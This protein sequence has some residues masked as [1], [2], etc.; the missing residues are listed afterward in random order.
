MF[1]YTG[2]LLDA[3]FFVFGWKKV[4]LKISEANPSLGQGFQAF[5]GFQVG[6]QPVYLGTQ[7]YLWKNKLIGSISTSTLKFLLLT[8]PET[9]HK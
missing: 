7:E 3:A 1:G 9:T 4:F 5:G 6:R 8:S 2:G